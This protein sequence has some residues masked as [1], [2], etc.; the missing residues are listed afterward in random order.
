[1]PEKRQF[2]LKIRLWQSHH[3]LNRVRARPSAPKGGR[4][5]VKLSLR[6]VVE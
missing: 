6:C 2:R 1:M 5:G 3:N 4:D